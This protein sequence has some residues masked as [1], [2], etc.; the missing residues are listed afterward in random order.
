MPSFLSKNTFGLL[1]L[2]L[3]M[4]ITSCHEKCLVNGCRT[5]M[6]HRHSGKKFK[7]RVRPWFAYQ[8][9]KIGHDYKRDISPD[10]I[11]WKYI[12]PPTPLTEEAMTASTDTMGLDFVDDSDLETAIPGVL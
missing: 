7:S 4:S 2:V 9:P 1:M 3:I 6:E 11:P 12:K 10:K 5:R 8:N